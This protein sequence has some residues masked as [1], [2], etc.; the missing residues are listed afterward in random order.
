[1]YK[2]LLPALSGIIAVLLLA[3][4]VF[5]SDSIKTDIN[6]N[7]V[8]LNDTNETEIN[9]IPRQVRTDSYKEIASNDLL[10]L[11]MNPMN[12]SLK[13]ENKETGFVWN[14]ALAE[15]D[16]TMNRTWQDFVASAVTIEYLERGT[17]RGQVSVAS[18]STVV[19]I[20]QNGSGFT[21]D[22]WFEEPQI[23]LTL[24]VHMEDDTLLIEVESESIEEENPD[25]TLQV[26]HL[27]PFFGAVKNAPGYIFIP[28]G[29]GALIKTDQKT[30]ATQPFSGRIYGEDIGITG[31]RSVGDLILPESISVPV[32]GI[33]REEN[34][35]GFI[36]IIEN[37]SHY[38]EIQAYP[39]GITT[40]YF[41]VASRFIYRETYHKPLDRKGN[42]MNVNQEH[43]NEFDAK[44]RYAF[45]TG[46]DADYT[47]MAL[48]YRQMLIEQGILQEQDFENQNDIPIRIEFLA[49]ENER[50]MLFKN[51]IP[52]TTV[53]QMRGILS[54]LYERQMERL[55]VAV[56]GWSR[57]GATG[58]SPQHFPFEA[59]TGSENQ[60]LDLIKDFENKN[61]PIHLY[62]DYV[63]AHDQGRGY[64]RDEIAQSIS[65][66]L[67]SFPFYH[68]LNPTV[69]DRTF[70]E[71]MERFK[72]YG[73]SNVAVDTLGERLFSAHNE[74]RTATRAETAQMYEGMFSNFSEQ[75][76]F[77]FYN[78]NVYLW[79]QTSHFFDIP[80]DSSGF[81]MAAESVPF[82]QILLRG[83]IDYY[84]SLFNFFGNREQEIL[85]HID[86][87]S[88]PSFI[89]TYEDPVK[90]LNTGSGW[91]YTSQYDVWRDEI[92]RVYTKINEAL[93]HVR[94]ASFTSRVELAGGVVKSAYSNGVLIIV[95]YAEKDFRYNDILIPAKDFFVVRGDER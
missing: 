23:G 46:K 33:I 80:M 66:Q 6:E 19:D 87:G 47:G 90:L 58:A 88:Y 95:N 72:R 77:A 41:W 92:T 36:A 37:G 42:V 63:I 18:E 45:L 53:E 9:E 30:I 16:E 76:R 79:K 54:N 35:N 61:I 39:A 32:F 85:R 93:K 70:R 24:I 57:G 94:G 38:A 20:V 60:W 29:S 28:D 82:L 52:M 86:Y 56:R 17:R 89:L 51:V 78:P 74:G 48:R 27:Y 84:G 26:V 68:M 15:P 40:P 13:V 22:L 83:S 12:L 2:R 64:R 3:L 4:I 14:S 49:A 73:I 71:Q 67:I 7:A 31:V 75:K 59:S 55:I 5:F 69:T 21:A 62:T 8:E 81:L 34:K 43:R 10:V 1:V 65:G 11:Y 25:Y 44:I 91:I 50:G